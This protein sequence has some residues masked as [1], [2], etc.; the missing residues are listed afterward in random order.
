VS[1]EQ[2][3]FN[4]HVCVEM[5]MGVPD[6]KRTGRLVQIRKGA[7]QFGTDVYLIRLRDGTLMSFENVMLRHVGDEG[8]EDAFYR[9]NGVIPPVIPDQPIYESDAED[10]EYTLGNKWP[11]TGFV[12]E[13]PKQPDSDV[14]SFAMTITTP[15]K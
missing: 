7:G 14:Q 13:N 6:E 2:F 5:L 3:A 9:S 15:T 4:D 12:I 8:F 10:A 11:E 1:A